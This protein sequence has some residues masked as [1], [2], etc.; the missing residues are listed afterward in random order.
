M[1][2]KAQDQG[3]AG[4]EKGKGEKPKRERKPNK[5]RRTLL[6][7]AQD[8]V[9]QLMGECD[10]IVA[11]MEPKQEWLSVAQEK[12]D[13]KRAEFDRAA[14]RLKALKALEPV[15][16]GIPQVDDQDVAPGE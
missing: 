15:F 7:Q 16:P 6:E 3:E 13:A 4:E 8:D 1:G 2:R 9:D 10:K 14:A 5:P 12:L 11:K